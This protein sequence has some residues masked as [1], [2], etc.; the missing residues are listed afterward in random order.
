MAVNN[1]ASPSPL[2]GGK[3]GW[4]RTGCTVAPNSYRSNTRTS[5]TI[6]STSSG[7]V[8]TTRITPSRSIT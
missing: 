6:A 1:L 7:G 2:A 8:N 4:R 5:C 3:S